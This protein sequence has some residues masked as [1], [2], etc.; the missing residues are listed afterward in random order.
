VNDSKTTDGSG[1]ASYDS[2]ITGLTPS[3]DYYVRAYATNSA[4]SAYSSAIIF[5]TLTSWLCV[6]AAQ[7][8]KW[9]SF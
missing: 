5:Q 7:I 4:G 3:T 8:K 1:S 9:F 6:T 2:T